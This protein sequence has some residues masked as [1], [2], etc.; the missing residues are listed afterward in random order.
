M[1]RNGPRRRTVTLAS[2]LSVTRVARRLLARHDRRIGTSLAGFSVSKGRLGTLINRVKR[3]PLRLDAPSLVPRDRTLYRLAFQQRDTAISASLSE[4]LRLSAATMNDNKDQFLDDPMYLCN[5]TID[6]L[7]KSHRP[8]S[9]S[10]F[11]PSSSS[12]SPNESHFTAL[13]DDCAAPVS[14][15]DLSMYFMMLQEAQKLVSARNGDH[16]HKEHEVGWQME[17]SPSAS[18]SPAPAVFSTPFQ[19][20]EASALPQCISEFSTGTTYSSPASIGTDWSSTMSRSTSREPQGPVPSFRRQPTNHGNSCQYFSAGE[21]V[22]KSVK[23]D[24]PQPCQ[25]VYSPFD[26]FQSVAPE[27]GNYSPFHAEASQAPLAGPTGGSML[28]TTA[29]Q[30]Y[31]Q[32]NSEA[33][34]RRAPRIAIA[35]DHCKKRKVRCKTEGN[36]ACVQC[37]KDR[38]QCIKVAQ[39]RKRGPGKKTVAKLEMERHSTPFFGNSNTV[40]VLVDSSNKRMKF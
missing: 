4:V 23:R 35:C 14:D 30:P 36:G 15:Y 5:S 38:C 25:G 13:S 20:S 31:F 10:H 12:S 18:P 7:H 8:A 32:R 33:A 37:I 40:S 24:L 39:N 28:R 3:C 22:H 6:P 21:S 34:S 27:A 1:G 11:Q 19:P 16:N 2:R 9:G 17:T 29:Q 26:R